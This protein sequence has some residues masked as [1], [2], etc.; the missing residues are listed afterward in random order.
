M[1][2][3]LHWNGLDYGEIV[4]IGYTT[5]DTMY[6]PGDDRSTTPHSPFN[7]PSSTF[8]NTTYN[9]NG[10]YMRALGVMQEYRWAD[11]IEVCL[12]SPG[13][14]YSAGSYAQSIAHPL[15]DNPNPITSLGP[16]HSGND[17]AQNTSVDCLQN[18]G[19]WNQ[20]CTWRT[21]PEVIQMYNYHQLLRGVHQT[22]ISAQPQYGL[23][24]PNI[25]DDFIHTPSYAWWVYVSSRWK[26]IARQGVTN[27]NN[28]PEFGFVPPM[29]PYIKTRISPEKIFGP[30]D[31]PWWKFGGQFTSPDIGID[32]TYDMNLDKFQPVELY[33]TGVTN[34]HSSLNDQGST[35]N[36]PDDIQL[37]Q[38]YYDA[39]TSINNGV[40][41]GGQYDSIIHPLIEAGLQAFQPIYP[42]ISPGSTQ[43]SDYFHQ[44][45][46]GPDLTYVISDY[47]N[48]GTPFY[49]LFNAELGGTGTELNNPDYALP[50]T[51]IAQFA[52]SLQGNQ[53]IRLPHATFAIGPY[54]PKIQSGISVLPRQ[55]N[56]PQ[57]GILNTTGN[58][59]A[60]NGWL[61]GDTG[62]A[63]NSSY[64]DLMP[65]TFTENTPESALL[66]QTYLANF[67]A[68]HTA[69]RHAILGMQPLYYSLD[70][71]FIQD[72]D[73]MGLYQYDT[74]TGLPI[75]HNSTTYT[76]NI[77]NYLLMLQNPE[78]Y[79]LTIENWTKLYV[80]YKRY[81]ATNPS[82][83][84]WPNNITNLNSP[85]SAVDMH[86]IYPEWP[87]IVEGPG[88]GT[89]AA[90]EFAA[91]AWNK[92]N[93][94][95]SFAPL[96]PP[97]PAGYVPKCG[98]NYPQ[99]LGIP[100]NVSPDT[101]TTT[102][103]DGGY[104][105]NFQ[106]GINFNAENA[107]TLTGYM[108]ALD[109]IIPYGDDIP[110]ELSDL[111]NSYSNTPNGIEGCENQA[112]LIYEFLDKELWKY[113]Y[114]MH[115]AVKKFVD[116][117]NT[118]G[119]DYVFYPNLIPQN[120]IMNTLELTNREKE[121]VAYARTLDI[122]MASTNTSYQDFIQQ[123]VN[124]WNPFL[125][126]PGGN[127]GMP[128]II[129]Y[130]FLDNIRNKLIQLT[131]NQGGIAQ[132]EINN[133]LYWVLSN[134]STVFPPGGLGGGLP[135][136][137]PIDNDFSMYD[138]DTELGT[139]VTAPFMMGQELQP[140]PNEIMYTGPHF[141]GSTAGYWQVCAYL[142][143]HFPNGNVLSVSKIS[144]V[145]NPTT[146]NY[147]NALVYAT[148]PFLTPEGNIETNTGWYPSQ[149][150]SGESFSTTDH[151]ILSNTP[152]LN[153]Q[154]L[155]QVADTQPPF[156]T[157]V[158]G[159]TPEEE[160]PSTYFHGNVTIAQ[161]IQELQ[162]AG[163]D[164]PTLDAYP[165]TADSGGTEAGNGIINQL[166]GLTIFAQTGDY[167][168]Y[169]FIKWCEITGLESLIQT[170]FPIGEP[171][172]SGENIYPGN[173]DIPGL[174][175]L[176]Y[177][178]PN[179]I[180]SI[181]EYNKTELEYESRFNG[182][183]KGKHLLG[184]NAQSSSNT[185]QRINSRYDEHETPR[186]HRG[187]HTEN[188]TQ[189][190]KFSNAMDSSNYIN[191]QQYGPG[192][193][194]L[195]GN[196]IF[197]QSLA[198]SNDAY[199]FRIM[200]GDPDEVG[201]QPV[202]TV[203]YGNIHGS[204][205]LK[206]SNSASPSE[207]VYKQYASILRNLEVSGSFYSLSGSISYPG[208][209]N[210]D[211]V[212]GQSFAKPDANV[213]I[214]AANKEV[215]GDKLSDKFILKLEGKN[216][217]GHANTL[218]LTSDFEHPVYES[219]TGLKRLTIVSGSWKPSAVGS[220]PAI[221]NV[222][223]SSLHTLATHRRFGYF[224]P[225]VGI[226]ILNPAVGNQ[227]LGGIPGEVGSNVQ[228]AF[229]DST[230]RNNGLAPHGKSKS[231]KEY[232]NALLLANCMRNRGDK[233]TMQINTET[234]EIHKGIIVKVPADALNYSLNP[235][236]LIGYNEEGEFN[237][238]GNSMTEGGGEDAKGSATTYPNQIQLYN[239]TGYLVAVA[240]FSKA[241]RKDFN[242]ELVIKVVLPVG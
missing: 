169:Q 93:L 109:Y 151:N 203:A 32:D 102:P 194:I 119:D 31:T 155:V 26:V 24:L 183:F 28:A 223:G 1:N 113:F 52:N 60:Q 51:F 42:F 14:R 9:V 30:I 130:G 229:N 136:P 239:A 114:T 142:N 73:L 167:R 35:Q 34:L 89:G 92:A 207:A 74:T 29:I 242:K 127:G 200:N 10:R 44:H 237:N 225:E 174:P 101:N 63:I 235:S 107:D 231:D 210:N 195:L 163:Y 15:G 110:L 122:G 233:I 126:N 218:H 125:D 70:E 5:A 116:S 138:D 185:N 232:N 179:A 22:Q 97:A 54:G 84:D 162:L 156:M 208:F 188:I 134:G 175:P 226:W 176:F 165:T 211:I 88:G 33:F 209:E 36:I 140:G 49:N 69:G 139:F 48:E 121:L 192:S 100:F 55:F 58:I 131:L 103:N 215:V 99:Y 146:Y 184:G 18:I 132:W 172:G 4:E 83:N 129:Q 219:G 150:L 180:R 222:V 145:S 112:H 224:Y 68:R 154:I 106:C 65:Y 105:F 120:L 228:V 204:G 87:H 111:F 159:I 76:G 6:Y 157:D 152:G 197:T 240:N 16:L 144:N 171:I 193:T 221:D 206:Q 19:S 78:T 82:D 128:Q 238:F 153:H 212:T 230:Q 147:A 160:W 13:Q 17:A 173:F 62:E 199:G 86:A 124:Q 143:E 61:P 2:K 166:D 40:P 201:A 95:G 236:R 187:L 46:P 21:K 133:F 50:G 39:I 164:G 56:P 64:Q 123:T 234:E 71:F 205:S 23:T 213:F 117:E 196:Q 118:L 37:L 80:M 181:G 217:N 189:A 198:Q 158:F 182:P 90:A 77:S 47:I 148:Q 216:S 115:Q 191:G 25:N 190:G 91:T 41:G 67:Y 43:M 96:G 161:M 104:P 8:E 141:P 214:I 168:P 20:V 27:N 79:E 202:F 186:P 45:P 177:I 85:L 135:A 3:E 108:T 81:K 53:T 241:I 11:R 7:N 149:Y 59:M 38:E 227:V 98:V 137:T 12:A 57:D 220:S 170:Y 94:R 75:N 66:I 178:S 72:Y